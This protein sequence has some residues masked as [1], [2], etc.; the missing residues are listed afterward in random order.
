MSAEEF[1]ND[2]EILRM[3]DLLDDVVSDYQKN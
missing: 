3:T 2:A 1:T